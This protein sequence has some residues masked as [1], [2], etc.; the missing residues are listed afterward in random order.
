MIGERVAQLVGA[1]PNG[2]PS[3]PM[4][5]VRTLIEKVCTVGDVILPALDAAIWEIMGTKKF[6]PAISEVL[7]IV[8]RQTKEWNERSWAIRDLRYLAPDLGAD[9]GAG[10]EIVIN[11]AGNPGNRKG[12]DDDDDLLARRGKQILP[13]GPPPLWRSLFYLWTLP[14]GAALV[15]ACTGHRPPDGLP[16]QHGWSDS[17]AQAC[18]DACSAIARMAGDRAAYVSV[19]HGY[20]SHDLKKL[21]AEKR[22][23]KP[24]SNAKGSRVIEYLYS[25]LGERH[26]TVK[27][28]KQRVYY[29]KGGEDIDEH[30]EPIV[31]PY[32]MR[33]DDEVGFITLT[34]LKKGSASGFRWL[35]PSLEE[36]LVEKRRYRR[37][38]LE[39][40]DLAAL[41]AAMVQAHPDRGGSS[42]AFIEARQRYVAARRACRSHA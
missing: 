13:E 27:R 40:P 39:Q 30:G 34:K 22:R 15:L 41:K 14:L 6:L 2:A 7:V 11:R 24:P 20:A 42:A 8:N 17:E 10:A 12:E 26:R 28:T 33:S 37:V 5:Y 9:R 4:V 23:A 16:S 35:Y 38:E 32:H 3:D 1:F 25:G 29:L 31:N 21:N 19:H 18:N 36:M